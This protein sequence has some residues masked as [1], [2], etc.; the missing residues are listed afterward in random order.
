MNFYLLRDLLLAL[1]R[2]TSISY[3]MPVHLSSQRAVSIL[4]VSF[5]P[6]ELVGVTKFAATVFQAN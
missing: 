1:I 6:L 4:S 2:C 3:E 5:T